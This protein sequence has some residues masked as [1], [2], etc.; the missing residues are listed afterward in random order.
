M[1]HAY[2]HVT[3]G[4]QAGERAG[5]EEGQAQAAILCY[6]TVELMMVKLHALREYEKLKALAYSPGRLLVRE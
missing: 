1:E 6:A 4:V 2:K 3:L 5:E